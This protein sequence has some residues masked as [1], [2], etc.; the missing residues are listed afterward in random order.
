MSQPIPK[1]V[2]SSSAFSADQTNGAAT[3]LLWLVMREPCVAAPTRNIAKPSSTMAL[4]AS[5]AGCSGAQ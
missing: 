2:S 3:D 4:P 5:C 1:S